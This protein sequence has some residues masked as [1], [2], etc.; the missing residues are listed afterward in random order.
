MKNASE[1]NCIHNIT[2]VSFQMVEHVSK[3][4]FSLVPRPVR[5]YLICCTLNLPLYHILIF[6]MSTTTIYP[7][8]KKMFPLPFY[9]VIKNLLTIIMCCKYIQL[10]LSNSLKAL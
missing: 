8:L 5:G 3:L 4:R 1:W 10:Y 6:N 9:F 7:P 2:Q